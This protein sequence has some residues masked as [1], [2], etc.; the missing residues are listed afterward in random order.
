MTLAELEG[1]RGYCVG[2]ADR[3]R[4]RLGLPIPSDVDRI[5][6][7]EANIDR[8][9]R[10]VKFIERELAVPNMSPQPKAKWGAK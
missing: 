10:K 1:K 6:R 8:E 3:L 9:D 5:A 2:A 7:I 4:G